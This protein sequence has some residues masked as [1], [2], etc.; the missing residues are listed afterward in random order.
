MSDDKTR[1]AVQ[2]VKFSQF[3]KVGPDPASK[4]QVVGLKSNEN[5]R[6]DL[7]TD[8]VSTNSSVVFR[9]SKGRFKSRADIPELNNQL[10]V[11]RFL[12]EQI[13]KLLE[14]PETPEPP[15]DRLPIFAEDEPTEYP[16]AEE[17]ESTDL[18]AGD[19]WYQVTEPT[20][21]YD[22]PDPEGLDLFIWTEMDDGT[23][24]WVLFEEKA[25][26]G[27][28]IIKGEA[29]DPKEDGVGNGSLWFDNTSDVMQLF[30]WH[31]DSDAWISVAPP[32]TLEGRVSTGEATQQAIIAQIQESLIEQQTLKNKVSALEGAIGDHSLLFT[33][34]STNPREGEFNLKNE[35]FQLTSYLSDSKYLTLNE[36]DRDGNI[37]NLSRVVVGDVLRL[38]DISRQVAEL[39]VTDI[40][41]GN[42]FAFEKLSGNLERFSE[43]PYDFILLSSFDPAGLATI[44]Y[45]DARDETKLGKTAANVVNNN[46]RIK[47]DSN[48]YVSTAGGELALSRVKTPT[49]DHHAVN[50]A[51]V[52][53]KTHPPA[54]TGDVPTTTKLWK[55]VEDGNKNDLR[56]DEFTVNFGSNDTVEVLMTPYING[57]WWAPG[58]ATNYSHA[59]GEQYAT[60]TDYQGAVALGFKAWKWWFMQSGTNEA[61]TTTYHNAL[62]GDWL[63]LGFPETYQL[64]DGHWYN[65][66]FPSPFPLVKFP[67]D[68]H[69]A[70]QS[71]FGIDDEPDPLPAEAPDMGEV[72][73]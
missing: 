43:G 10:E 56:S 16:H 23:F 69:S 62:Q 54:N 67:E 48:V 38:S 51:Y 41:G 37:I 71:S 57:R 70:G 49:S 52:D 11:N 2:G 73:P 63:K 36:T 40:T 42:V 24:E 39:Q 59:I 20:F 31:T 18:E 58:S 32:T 46:F 34:T 8:L 19:Q 55:Y 22:N 60:I 7:T 61:G 68:A 13:E 29:P 33:S 30:V 72:M 14:E 3:K 5:V 15:D 12:W 35:T 65:L 4:L 44:D 17:D 27:V 9:D 25:P 47:S 66:N 28:V 50:K 1:E 45:V 26:D 53:E 21:D 6:A 64:K